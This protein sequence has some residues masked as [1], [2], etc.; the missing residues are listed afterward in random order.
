MKQ[1]RAELAGRMIGEVA[2]SFEDRA[3]ARCN[4]RLLFIRSSPLSDQFLNYR[5]AEL[6]EL[7]EATGVVDRASQAT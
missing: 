3:G 6:T 2:R 4:V 7:F 1:L 5:A